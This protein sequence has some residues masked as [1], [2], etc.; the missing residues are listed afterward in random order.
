MEL[1]NIFELILP[2]CHVSSELSG[3]PEIPVWGL[4]PQVPVTCHP[5]APSN[6]FSFLV[7]LS[8]SASWSW[9]RV[10]CRRVKVNSGIFES[11]KVLIDPP[12]VAPKFLSRM[13]FSFSC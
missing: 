9:A 1:R 10:Y 2:F 4:M 13:F 3:E 5:A 8:A 11:T 7:A 12:P 6:V